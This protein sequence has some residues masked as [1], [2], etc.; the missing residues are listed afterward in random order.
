MI[1]NFDEYKEFAKELFRK[2][3]CMRTEQLKQF[4]IRYYQMDE[5]SAWSII[6]GLQRAENFWLSSDGWA[7]TKGM[8]QRLL[9]DRFKEHVIVDDVYCLGKM[10]EYASQYRPDVIKCLWLVIDMLPQS[11]NFVVSDQP[12]NIMFTIS[13]KDANDDTP[14]RL[15]QLVYISKQN[16]IVLPEML[17]AFPKIK[18]KTSRNYMRRIA[19][20]D[21]PEAVWRIPYIGFSNIVQ[22]DESIPTRCKE[23]ADPDS[24][25]NKDIRWKDE[26]YQ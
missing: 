2:V 19:L 17:R 4:F 13:P 10:D 24:K 15:Y 6:L 14:S 20:I 8:Y 5:N 11:I 25:R 7:M 23:I 9:H 22:Y 21:N 16:E 26:D 1:Y 3:P 18:D 12:Y